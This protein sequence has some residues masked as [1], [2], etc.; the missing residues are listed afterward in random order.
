MDRNISEYKI[1]WARIVYLIIIALFIFFIINQIPSL[2]DSFKDV[3]IAKIGSYI[4]IFGVVLLSFG[5]AALSYMA[6]SLKKLKF[7]RTLIM[8]FASNTLNKLLP[9]G[10]GAM[11]ANYLYLRR[12]HLSTISSATTVAINNF[13]G[14][15]ASI[16]L[17]LILLLSNPSFSL[18]LSR[19]DFG[20]IIL[21]T[22]AIII[23]V[24]IIFFVRSIH[25]KLMRLVHSFLRQ[26][27]TYRE[28]KLRLFGAFMSQLS[29]AFFN[30]LSLTLSMHTVG[31]N[32]N[33][34]EVMII[35]SLA[36]WFGSLIPAPGGFGSVDA[37]LVAAFVAYGTALPQALATVLVFRLLNFW[38]PL[39]I[40][41]PAL[42]YVR[43]KQYI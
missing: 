30:I 37:G 29:L 38:A 23:I 33:I 19:V 1:H 13:L 25:Y 9:A 26:L 32:L 12:N 6:L 18:K 3:K 7:S 24:I 8:Q 15:I 39:L 11:G 14:V 10:I 43:A 42:I 41:I 28:H 36:I 2:K 35:Y 20:T 40:G 16:F 34:L 17:L 31:G 5:M 22:L 27:V 4:V 21:L